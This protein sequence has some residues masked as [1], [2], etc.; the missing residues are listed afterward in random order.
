M[1]KK[2][3]KNGIKLN[4]TPT[5]K[6]ASTPIP[7]VAPTE[8]PVSAPAVN[9]GPAPKPLVGP[10]PAPAKAPW[11]VPGWEIYQRLARNPW[12]RFVVLTLYYLA[13]IA[14]LVVMY[15]RG[16]FSTPPFIYQ[17]F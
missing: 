9:P 2:A 5:A 14:T 13:I 8:Q 7:S 6:P 1:K 17:G 3:S 12:L 16:D 4:L 10:A 15:G 11:S